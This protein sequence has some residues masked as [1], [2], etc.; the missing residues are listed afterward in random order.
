ML[1]HLARSKSV[2][3]ES[4]LREVYDTECQLLYV[5]CTCA[6]DYPLV[7][8]VS[9]GSEFLADMAAPTR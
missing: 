2:T 3:D 4:D 1:P 8:A 7:A 9:Q 6:R 5:A